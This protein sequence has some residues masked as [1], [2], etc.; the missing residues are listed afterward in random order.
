[1]TVNSIACH[2]QPFHSAVPARP[3]PS[4]RTPPGPIPILFG[5]RSRSR[6][7]GRWCPTMPIPDPPSGIE[8]PTGQLARV[9]LELA[10]HTGES[11]ASG[12]PIS[13]M[14]ARS[15]GRSGPPHSAAGFAPRRPG[16]LSTLPDGHHRSTI[17]RPT[18]RLSATS[19]PPRRRSAAV[20]PYCTVRA[21]VAGVARR[22]IWID[23]WCTVAC[24]P[25]T[26]R[27]PGE[28][29][30]LDRIR[31]GRA[32]FAGPRSEAS[33]SGRGP[34]GWRR[35]TPPPTQNSSPFVCGPSRVSTWVA[36]HD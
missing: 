29:P 11:N 10:I 16:S 2:V 4:D 1:M 7:D 35:S 17:P 8:T 21:R 14:D 15:T 6:T 13:R 3:R 26:T 34:R 9:D 33:T 25:S 22:G 23:R 32:T 19:V 5:A 24:A 12:S 20:A 36:A 31:D 27:M 18:A 30:P 28:K